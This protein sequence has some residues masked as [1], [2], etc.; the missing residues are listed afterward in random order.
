MEASEPEE[1]LKGSHGRSAPVEPERELIKVRLE[2]LVPDAVMRAAQ[3]GLQVAEDA[4]HAWEQL[5][6]ALR[7]ALR[8]R[9]VAIAHG[10]ERRVSLPAVG[11]DDRTWFHRRLDE[12]T[13]RLGRGV[14]ND[15]QAHTSGRAT[16]NLDGGHDQS[17]FL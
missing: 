7:G 2:V 13:E 15:P 8:A 10:L 4:V 11:H 9:S 12:A 1:G 14:G 17:L 6:R 3:P 5:G 16:P